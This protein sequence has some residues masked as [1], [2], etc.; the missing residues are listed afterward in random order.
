MPVGAGPSGAAIADFNGDG[1]LDVAVSNFVGQTVVVLLRQPGGGFAPGLG[2][3]IPFAYRLGA[4]AAGDFAGDAAPDLA[5]TNWDG[6]GAKILRREGA[7]FV[8]EAADLPTGAKPRYIATGDF[9]GAGGTDVAITNSGAGSVTVLLRQGA[10]FAQETGSP[11][12][13]GGSPQN[14]LAR[15]FNGDARPDLAVANVGDDNVTMLLRQPGG[16]FTHAPGSPYGVGDGPVPIA[17]GDF[18]S[19]GLVDIVT[20]DQSANAVTVL[21]RRADGGFTPDPS[22]PVATA[23]GATDVAVTDVNR[24]G[25]PDLAVANYS[26]SSVTILLNT[27]PFPHGPPPSGPVDVDRDGVSP[28]LDCDDNNPAIRPG[29]RDIPGNKIDENCDQRDAR[30]PLLKRRIR[31]ITATYPSGYMTFTSM[32]VAP[33]RKGDRLRLTCKGKGCDFKRKAIRVKKKSSKRSLMKYVRGMELRKGAVVQLR[34]TRT[35]T[36][37]RVRTW[38]VRAPRIPRIIDRCAQPGAKKLIRCP[39]G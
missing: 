12:T 1:R 13:V 10:G 25:R 33:A 6:S 19:D 17:L 15:D 23:T 29:A 30:L 16:G 37:G 5:V 3:P 2:S 21:L 32:S 7:G 35:G 27:T 34:V 31:A 9:D 4:I 8:A 14:I 22:S 11:F 28:P 26:G 36:I 38:K 18:N 39:R 20:G 24:D